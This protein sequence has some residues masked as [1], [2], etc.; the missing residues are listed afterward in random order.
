LL[1]QYT[2]NAV[3]LLYYILKPCVKPTFA[4]AMVGLTHAYYQCPAYNE[5]NYVGLGCLY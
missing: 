2:V 5:H 1:L 4:A 3:L